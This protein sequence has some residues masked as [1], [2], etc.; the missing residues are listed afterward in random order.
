MKSWFVLTVLACL[1]TWVQPALAQDTVQ[2]MYIRHGESE[3]NRKNFLMYF[4]GTLTPTGRT[5]AKEAAAYIKDNHRD[6]MCANPAQTMHY[7]SPLRRA[8]ATW[9]IIYMTACQQVTRDIQVPPQANIRVAPELRE[10]RK[11]KSEDVN[12]GW[13]EGKHYISQIVNSIGTELGIPQ[14]TRQTLINHLT[15]SYNNVVQDRNRMF[16]GRQAFDSNKG[17]WNDQLQQIDTRLLTRA[18]NGGHLVD[19]ATKVVMVAHSGTGRC[20]FGCASGAVERPT[21]PQQAVRKGVREGNILKN[22]GL[23]ILHYDVANHVA[24]HRVSFK[25][26]QGKAPMT[27]K[28]VWTGGNDPYVTECLAARAILDGSFYS[29]FEKGTTYKKWLGSRYPY[30][31][32]TFSFIPGAGSAMSWA[33]DF[34]GSVVKTYP[35]LQNCNIANVAGGHYAKVTCGGSSQTFKFPTALVRTEFTNLFNRYRNHR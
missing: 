27:G 1:A 31:S 16:F 2:L 11:S 6:L 21:P 22:A 34:G 5:Q 17:Y 8:F 14:V 10:K 26:K 12:S 20:R 23:W 18:A 24:T 4:D 30:C 3:G 32:V 29:K 33:T 7:V 28:D 25:T 19:G 13:V 35:G 15:T 9:L